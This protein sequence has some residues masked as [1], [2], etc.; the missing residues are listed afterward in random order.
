MSINTVFDIEIR[1]YE[2]G[3]A[4]NSI[5]CSLNPRQ[6][7]ASI[8][9]YDGRTLRR[10][11]ADSHSDKP[12]FMRKWFVLASALVLSVIYMGQAGY[13]DMAKRVTTNV[14]AA[15]G[16]DILSA[17]SYRI[18][19]SEPEDFIAITQQNQAASIEAEIKANAANFKPVDDIG[20]APAQKEIEITT[21]MRDYTINP[22]SLHSNLSQ[23][24]HDA[25]TI[26]QMAIEF[27]QKFGIEK[28]S[29]K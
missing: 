24:E 21:P 29:A 9:Q 7:N 11:S 6:L 4:I 19:T 12:F 28:A 25:N 26:H 8:N 2:Q 14:K 18:L 13:F 22:T 10:R 17:E 16:V 5:G 23:I 20:Q 1:R 3:R 15:T 27:D